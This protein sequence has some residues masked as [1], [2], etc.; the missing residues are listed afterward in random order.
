MK[1]TRDTVKKN[2][3]STVLSV[4]PYFLTR[5]MVRLYIIVPKLLQIQGRSVVG[6]GL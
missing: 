3:K 1:S 2:M 5:K 4:F 6:I